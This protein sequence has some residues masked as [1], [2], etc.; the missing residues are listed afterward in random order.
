M[1][2]ENNLDLAKKDALRL[3]KVRPRS[4]WEIADRLSQKGYLSETIRQIISEIKAKGFLDDMKFA[5][6]YANDQLEL[7]FKGPRY[8]EYEL[9]NFRIKEE[10]IAK[11]IDDMMKGANLKELFKRFMKN[12]P[13]DSYDKLT[14]KLINRGFDP[15]TVR[16]LLRE[17]SKEMEVQ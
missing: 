16:N 14:E 8:I 15:Y 1:E 11:I 4:E 12:H 9:K 17:I 2:K 5:K 13:N 6:L 10:I 3:L 7:K